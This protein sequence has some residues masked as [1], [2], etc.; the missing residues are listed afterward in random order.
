MPTHDPLPWRPWSKLSNL[1]QL[2][3]ASY[4][5][6][7]VATFWPHGTRNAAGNMQLVLR[8]TRGYYDAIEALQ[9]VLD[10]SDEG[11]ALTE[12]DIE[13]VKDALLNLTDGGTHVDSRSV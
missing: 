9:A 3:I 7:D 1:D 12:L 8:A 4:D 10:A 11:R 5:N 6:R 2:S 13:R